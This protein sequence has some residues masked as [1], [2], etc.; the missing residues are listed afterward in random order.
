MYARARVPVAIDNMS[1]RLL[2]LITYN[3][4]N[5]RW[6]SLL[7]SYT[8]TSVREC[9]CGI[10]LCIIVAFFL[11]RIRTVSHPNYC[12]WQ[13]I[14][15]LRQ[16]MSLKQDQEVNTV[17]NVHKIVICSRS[18]C[19]THTTAYISVYDFNLLSPVVIYAL[20]SIDCCHWSGKHWRLISIRYRFSIYLSMAFDGVR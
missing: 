5:R 19:V 15:L 8:N 11:H 4:H 12:Y 10:F 16:F 6:C 20:I 17:F 13:T 9:E 18:L 7:V 3:L 1:N 2:N 14:D